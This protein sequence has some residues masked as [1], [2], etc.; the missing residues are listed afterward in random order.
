MKVVLEF[1][2]SLFILVVMSSTVVATDRYVSLSGGNVPPYTSWAT[3][4]RSI[5]P[6]VDVSVAGDTVI[7]TNG[8]YDTGTAVAAGRT[9]N[10]RLVITKSITVRSV[11]G[12][13]KTVI[14]GSGTNC[15]DTAMAV[16]CVYMSNGVLDGFTLQDG[17]TFNTN[18]APVS[19]EDRSGGG[20][21]GSTYAAASVVMNCIITNC[22]ANQ[23][24][25]VSR[26]TLYN[27]T[28]SG[29]VASGKTVTGSS[30]GGGAYDSTLN[31]CTLVGNVAYYGGGAHR[32]KLIGCTLRGNVAERGGGGHMSDFCSSKLVGNVARSGAGASDG[33]LVNCLVADNAG[34]GIESA[35]LFACTVANNI[36]GG[37]TSSSLFNCIVWSNS[38]SGGSASYSC[39]MSM[40]DGIGN[41]SVDP[42]FVDPAAGDYRLQSASPCRDAGS[43]A[44]TSLAGVDCGGNL[45]VVSETM[46]MGAFEWQTAGAD[47]PIVLGG[48]IAF[49]NVS[50]GTTAVRI[51]SIYNG[52][53]I[54]V[55]ITIGCPSGLDADWTGGVIEPGTTQDVSVSFAP[56]VATQYAGTISVFVEG[57]IASQRAFSGK[58]VSDS[59]G[60]IHY[61]DASRSDDSGA[62][63]SWVT[64]KRTIQAA[65]NLAAVGDTVLVTNG[66]YIIGTTP[67][68]GGTLPCRL[69]ISKAVTVRSVNGRDVTIIEGSGNNE[70]A[71]STAVRCVYMNGGVLDGFTLRR[72]ATFSD[73]QG[74]TVSPYDNYGGGLYIGASARAIN[75]RIV[76]CRAQYGGGSRQPGNA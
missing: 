17:A 76:S 27:C 28:L 72:G 57:S 67:T 12:P 2:V 64:A 26:A 30:Y 29:N 56:S 19:S 44:N 3:A 41:I 16:R 14:A 8:V 24:G 48:D 62:G 69:V 15:L 13:E 35:R 53:A 49:G 74:D 55:A 51:L 36:R 23:G 22:I 66:L 10:N 47:G 52:H 18:M 31:N 61:V 71:K 6:A 70:Y 38:V 21:Y 20:V 68:P 37:V 73:A 39:T 11:N 1:V 9:L 25:G 54:P 32:G 45:R 42:L 75:C 60:R 59:S 40:Q 34:P 50:I 4:A 33:S 43:L 58:G 5:Q 46:D 7:V 65:V 63:T